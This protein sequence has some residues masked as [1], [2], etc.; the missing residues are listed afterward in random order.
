MAAM[1]TRLYLGRVWSSHSGRSGGVSFDTLK[2]PW[3]PRRSAAFAL[4][5]KQ[6]LVGASPVVSSIAVTRLAIRWLRMRMSCL[7]TSCAQNTLPRP[8]SSLLTFASRWSLGTSISVGSA[9]MCATNYL[10]ITKEN[11]SILPLLTRVRV[12]EARK[13]CECTPVCR[14]FGC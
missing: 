14:V 6:L 4:S 12:R 5:Y 3:R 2:D 1:Y 13:G 7:H 8:Y 10:N 11:Y 9:P